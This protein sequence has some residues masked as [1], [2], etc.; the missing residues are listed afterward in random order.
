[1]AAKVFGIG[2]NKTA[3]RS[4]ASAMRL[5]GYRTLHK[6]DVATS[7]LVDRAATEGVPLLTYI[8]DRFDAYFDVQGIVTR[9]A[10][11]DHQYPDSKFILTTRDVDGWLASREKHAIANQTRGG[12]TD[13][14]AVVDEE[15]WI[16]EREAHHAAVEAYFAGRSNLLVM[17][18]VAGEGWERLA[19]FLDRKPPRSPFPW[20]NRDGSGTYRPDTSLDRARRRARYAFARARRLVR[21]DS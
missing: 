10:E 13:D 2:L 15:A 21:P 17:D 18:L 16:A 3:T 9:F 20:E 11:L 19:P 4:M 1:M 8:G 7:Q 5:L 14:F 6:G 12:Y